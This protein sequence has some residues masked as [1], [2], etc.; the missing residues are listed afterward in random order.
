M[1][2]KILEMCGVNKHYGGVH[3]LK[4]FDFELQ[5]GEIH[6]LVGQNGCAKTPLITIITGVTRSDC[7]LYTSR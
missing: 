4:D 1:A 6:C 5:S 7:L 3:A 2:E